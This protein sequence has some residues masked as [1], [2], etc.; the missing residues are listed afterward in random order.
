MEGGRL[1]SGAGEGVH[2]H[3][4]CV[5]DLFDGCR[6]CPR[7]RGRAGGLLA[8]A[9]LLAP[10]DVAVSGAPLNVGETMEGVE[11]GGT[12]GSNVVDSHKMS[13]CPVRSFSHFS[14]GWWD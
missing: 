7:D 6:H 8:L 3:T 1:E 9:R 4:V 2:V 14:L 13:V 12:G 10:L 11:G 5:F